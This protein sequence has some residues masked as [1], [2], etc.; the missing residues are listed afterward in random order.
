[1]G[2]ILPLK[3]KSG[4]VS[5]YAGGV[6][7]NKV[8]FIGI[9][10]IGVSGLAYLFL[11]KGYKVS[12]SDIKENL[13]VK[14]LRDKGVKINVPHSAQAVRGKDLVCFSSAIR[15][16]NPELLFAKALRIPRIKRGSLL[17]RILRGKETAAVSGSHGKTTV[18]ALA[19]FVLRSLGKDTASLVGGIPLYSERS[20]WWGRDLFIVETDESDGSFLKI[21]P[22]YSIITNIDKEHLNFYGSFDRLTQSFKK[23]ALNTRSLVIGC[24]EDKQVR[25]ILRQAGIPSVSYG[26]KNSNTFSAGNI[27]FSK[28]GSEF[29]FYYKKRFAGRIKIPLWGKHNVLNTLSVLA[30]CWNLGYGVKEIK[31]AVSKF[32]GTKRR[33]EIKAKVKKVSFIDDYAHHPSEIKAVLEAVSHLNSKRIVVLFQPHR[34]SRVKILFDKFP[35]AFSSADLLVVTDIYP[36]GEKPLKGIDAESLSRRIKRR[37]GRRIIYLPKNEILSKVP[38]MFKPGDLFLGLGAG[39]INKITDSIIVRFREG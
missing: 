31:K 21:K 12:G 24:G 17:G 10:G 39:D 28:K 25:S 38:G 11:D 14:K 35:S 20:S 26:F 33:L 36:A 30:L 7:V 19:S 2:R 27:S 18:T 13:I 16:D 3:A 15:P 1:M 37:L 8:H 23:F 5:I 6:R 9:G 22:D 34:F 4:K 32:P 29:D